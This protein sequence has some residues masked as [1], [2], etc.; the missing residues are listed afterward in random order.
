MRTVCAPLMHQELSFAE[1]VE[2]SFKDHDSNEWR[3]ALSLV[4]AA[5]DR[6]VT[7]LNMKVSREQ[8]DR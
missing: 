8:F 2:R 6:L 3:T 4:L 5:V 7:G 1:D